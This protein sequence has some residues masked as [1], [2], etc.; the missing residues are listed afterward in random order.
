MW[1]DIPRLM[2]HRQIWGLL[3]SRISNDGAFYFFVAWL[4]LYLSQARGFDLRQIALFAWL[5]FLAADVGS[6][7]G[8]WLGRWWMGRGCTLDRA[9]KR[10]IWLGALLV[11]ASLPAGIVDSPYAALALISLAMFAIQAKASSLFSLPADLFPSLRVASV[12]GLFGAAGSL[13]AALFSVMAGWVSMHY[14]WEPVF[15][16]VGITQLLSA[17]FISWFIPEIAI[18]EE[19]EVS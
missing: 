9:R 19:R 1:R 11:I 4:P 5:P 2:R 15:W 17:A 6:L 7:T 12:W 8:G 3:L 18:I 13:G 10:V 14:A 16:L